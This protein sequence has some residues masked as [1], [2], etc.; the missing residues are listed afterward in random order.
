MKSAFVAN[1]S[2]EIRNPMAS[3]MGYAE[4]LSARLKDPSDLEFVRIIKNSGEYLLTLIN[5]LLDLAKM[6]AGKLEIV[7]E[8]TAV[9]RLRWQ[10]GRT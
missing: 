7:R 6:E 1:V 4:L 3:L 10:A 9:L 2:H 5:D 8:P